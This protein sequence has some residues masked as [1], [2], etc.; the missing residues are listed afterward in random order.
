M[1]YKQQRIRFK[2]SKRKPK[3]TVMP[4]PPRETLGSFLS[5][6]V[7]WLIESK[8][9]IGS[10]M[11]GRSRRQQAEARIAATAEPVQATKRPA[12]TPFGRGVAAGMERHCEVS[13]M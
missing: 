13:C 8:P 5:P 12:T 3:A 1:R 10:K 7:C 2:P 9:G 4:N 6:E 11:V